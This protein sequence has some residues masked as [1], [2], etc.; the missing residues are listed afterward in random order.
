MNKWAGPLILSAVLYY[1]LGRFGL[2]L[3]IPPG[4]ASAVWPASGGALFCMI[5][6]R[7]P[8]VLLGVGLASFFVNLGVSSGNF[9]QLSWSATVPAFGIALGALFQV[10]FGYY[11]F[12]RLVGVHFLVDTPNEIL[13]FIIIVAPLGC[14]LAPTFG[15]STLYLLGFVS[16]QNY[17]FNWMTWWAGDCIGVLFFT[18]LLLTVFSKD[19]R[20]SNARKMQILLP[21][22]IIFIGVL[23]LFYSSTN[24]RNLEISREING[25]GKRFVG[26]IQTRLN[27]AYEK[28]LAYDA[29]FQSSNEVSREE[30]NQFSSVLLKTDTVF[31]AVG[32]TEIIPASEREKVELSIRQQGFADFHF[33]EL[34]GVG[35]LVSASPREEYF[36]VLYIYPYAENKPA[37]GLDLGANADRY[38]ALEQAL[39]LATPI[40]TKPIRLAQETAQQLALILYV[41]VFEPGFDNQNFDQQS[42][43]KHF[44]GFLSGVFRLSGIMGEAPDELTRQ[45]FGYRF[46]D[47]TDK[48]APII[49]A[50]SEQTI[51]SQFPLLRTQFSFGGRELEMVFYANN[52]YRQS[53]KD[54][55][56]WSILSGGLLLV[57][58]L[59]GFILLITGNASLINREVK[60]KTRE[61]T[62]AI[63]VADKA[64]QAKSAFTATISH[65]IRT[66]LN[67][68]I[69]LINQCLKTDLNSKQRHYLQ[70]TKL[71]SS[72]LLSLINLTLDFAKIE[73]GKLEIEYIEFNLTEILQKIFAVFDNQASQKGIKFKL[74]LPPT[75]PSLLL[76]DPLRIEQILLNLCSNGVKFTERGQVSLRARVQHL[77][78]EKLTV[79]LIVAD[80][81]IGIAQD[82]QD[83]LFESFQQ[84][85]SSMSRK[86][87]GSGLGLAISKQ[88]TELMGGT[89]SLISKENQG[90]E[91]SVKLE[92]G[93]VAASENICT[94]V[95][96][97]GEKTRNAD[98]PRDAV[99]SNADT[100]TVAAQ[101]QSISGK[102]LEDR[103]I[104][105]VEDVAINQ[106]IATEMLEEQ[107]A[108]VSVAANG[109]QAIEMVEQQSFDIV[110]M[111]IQM[112]EMDGYEATKHIRKD[113]RFAALPIIAMTANAMQEDID[114]AKA[115]GMND[116]IAKPIDE[117]DMLAKILRYL[118]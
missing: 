82:K 86:F 90:T 38:T 10:Y 98:Q 105:L 4:F 110:L 92:L 91:F 44:K 78:D 118:C 27:N 35:E 95:L 109:Q 55:T 14:L 43:Q 61:L 25:N 115:A 39:Q 13:K 88:L 30:F 104:L 80:T 56:S 24:A 12:R 21:V 48:Q 64:N 18:P 46:N 59:Q 29:F 84:A 108:I 77:S 76:G 6:F 94:E 47:I 93:K 116:H 50:S 7:H 33:T 102:P 32:W 60:R 26:Q 51:S 22:M 72:T 113:P 114:R 5:Y 49:L 9:Q 89:I 112:P 85:D 23:I 83:K 97:A 96:L 111:D 42:I 62:H 2:T 54:W 15:V 75:L 45:D 73:S 63:E 66:P 65:E 36:P 31:Q 52:Q 40:A 101:Q 16:A 70:Q 11:L 81:G 68:I 53:S 100:Q 37:F 87:G 117:A 74:E 19:R 8:A 79:Q 20:V 41:P 1:L 107:G 17:A 34:N 69:G 106:F 99:S 58:M 3:A 28:L 71:A 67:A 103:N 57:A